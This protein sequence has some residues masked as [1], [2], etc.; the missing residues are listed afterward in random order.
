MDQIESFYNSMLLLYT[1]FLDV[2][3]TIGQ[4]ITAAESGEFD[5]S[6]YN[7]FKD[8]PTIIDMG[9]SY[10]NYGEDL[11]PGLEAAAAETAAEEALEYYTNLYETTMTLYN[12]NL[13]EYVSEKVNEYWDLGAGNAEEKGIIAGE[14]IVY[15]GEIKDLTKEY[16]DTING[17]LEDAG[18]TTSAGDYNHFPTYA[19]AFKDMYATSLSNMLTVYKWIND[20]ISVDN[21]LDDQATEDE[22]TYELGNVHDYY[23]LRL[24]RYG[25]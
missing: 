10:E 20:T 6:Y 1:N 13:Y 17:L 11:A 25:T 21:A 15:I 12:T 22:G 3:G 18:V 2:D 9:E 14:V 7:E 5:L 8:L 24:F 19:S 4:Q 23:V 16:K